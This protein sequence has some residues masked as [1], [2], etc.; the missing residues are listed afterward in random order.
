MWNSSRPSSIY[1][2]RNNCWTD[3]YIFR[4][5]TQLSSTAT[6]VQTSLSSRLLMSLALRGRL[7]LLRDSSAKGHSGFEKCRNLTSCSVLCSGHNRWSTIRHDKGK[8]DA[9]KSKERLSI[10][11]ELILASKSKDNSLLLLSLW[12]VLY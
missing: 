5:H 10:S 4:P 12:L 9:T 8:N 1:F 6:A 2:P 3:V 7:Y 11:K